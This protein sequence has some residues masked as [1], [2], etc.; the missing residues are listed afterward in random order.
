MC[1]F[2][3]LQNIS[4]EIMVV[5]QIIDWIQEFFNRIF[6]SLDSR[7]ILEVRVLAETW[8]V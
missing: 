1:V 2:V 3:C 7:A 8:A 6:L 4:K 5:I